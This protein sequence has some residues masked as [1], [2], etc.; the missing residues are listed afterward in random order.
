MVPVDRLIKGR[1][2]DNFEFVQWFRKFFDANYE[3]KGRRHYD[4][5][6][7]RAG[8]ALTGPSSTLPVTPSR[9]RC[10]DTPSRKGLRR[11]SSASQN[12][13]ISLESLNFQLMEL[14]LT[15]ESL[16]QERDFYF[17]KL[18]A[19]ECVVEESGDSKF[20]QAVREIL[21]EVSPD[22]PVSVEILQMSLI[23]GLVTGV[24]CNVV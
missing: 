2:Q 23:P 6:M 8:Q 7:E 3:G 21:Y 13:M 15:L 18:T 16:E 19:I 22:S 14:R 20:L 11:A 5:L 1:F 9:G 4:P 10:H 24:S 17:S 12:D